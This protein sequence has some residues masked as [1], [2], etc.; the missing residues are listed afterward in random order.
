MEA[1]RS[2]GL[3]LENGREAQ[4]TP[5]KNVSLLSFTG[6]LC[7]CVFFP[8]SPVSLVFLQTLSMEEKSLSR[9]REWRW[10][11]RNASG[12]RGICIACLKNSVWIRLHRV[13][14]EEDQVSG[15]GLD[16]RRDLL[17]AGA[18]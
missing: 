6:D 4:S 1:G 3:G 15:S 17:E 8:V 5:I 12:G 13:R 14:G 7:I 11:D 2:W 18:V 9:E 16:K 10:A